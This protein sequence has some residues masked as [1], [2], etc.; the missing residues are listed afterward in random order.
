[1]KKILFLCTHNSA[2]SQMAKA[3][4]KH[5]FPHTFEVHSAGT[6]PTLVNE[7]AIKV[8]NE[9]GID[10]STYKSKSISEFID[11]EFDFVITVCDQAKES[12]PIF[13]KAKKSLHQS[14]EDPAAL[15]GDNENK[16]ILFRKIRDEIKEYIDKLPSLLMK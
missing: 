11:Q 1:M 9:V 6:H 5:L 7:N 2:R 12:C 16:I 8:I 15:K 13:Y 3:F 10:I 14:F 4:T